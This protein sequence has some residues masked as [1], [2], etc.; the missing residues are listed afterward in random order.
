MPKILLGN[1]RGG[2]GE[3]ALKFEEEVKLGGTAPAVHAI[4]LRAWRT[5]IIFITGKTRRPSNWAPCRDQDGAGSGISLSISVYVSNRDG[6]SKNDTGQILV[7]DQQFALFSQ[8]WLWFLNF[9]KHSQW[10]PPSMLVHAYAP[11]CAVAILCWFPL[12][13]SGAHS[14]QWSVDVDWPQL[15]LN[16]I[17]LHTGWIGVREWAACILFWVW[18]GVCAWGCRSMFGVSLFDTIICSGIYYY[19]SL[20]VRLF[21]VFPLIYFI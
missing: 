8:Y 4:I 9:S 13:H 17:D 16:T 14:V 18:A 3:N 1:G 6:D 20:L 7:P 15:E 12:V 10:V 5:T 11:T 2:F 21:P 19:L